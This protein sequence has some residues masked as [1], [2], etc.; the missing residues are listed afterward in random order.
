MLPLNTDKTKELIIDF[1]I[2]K[3]PIEN[4]V[5]ENKVIE[6]VDLYVYLGVSV[7]RQLNWNAQTSSVISKLNKRMYFLRKLGTFQI[8]YTIMSLFYCSVMESVLK[9]CIIG[10]GGNITMKN[11]VLFNRIISRAS[12]VSKTTF[13]DFDTLFYISCHKKIN[14]IENTD[15]PLAHQ[16]IR[17]ARSGRPRFLS[18]RTERYRKSFL[19]YSI[20]LLNFRR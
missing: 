14:K 2:N 1:R 17:S 4:L 18:C 3:D 9:F 8:D 5:I 11:K 16:I 10:W 7:D 19:P 13:S 12:K 15:H 20:T 6:Q